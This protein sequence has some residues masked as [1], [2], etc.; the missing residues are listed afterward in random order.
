MGH[1]LYIVLTFK[2]ALCFSGFDPVLKLFIVNLLRRIY[3]FLLTTT[4]LHRRKLR[5]DFSVLL[6]QL[7][8][9][10]DAIL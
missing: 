9:P 5:N 8:L 2:R 6:K 1:R 4:F 7:N 3:K 10:D